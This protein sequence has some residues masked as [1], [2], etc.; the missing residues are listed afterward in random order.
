MIE[1]V[2]YYQFTYTGPNKVVYD[3][4]VCAIRGSERACP[5]GGVYA[6]R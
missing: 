5:S 1:W 4:S 2:M 3:I 6:K